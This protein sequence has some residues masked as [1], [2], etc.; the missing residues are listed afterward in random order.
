MTGQILWPP[1]PSATQPPWDGRAAMHS[2]RPQI[3]AQCCRSQESPSEVELASSQ[4]YGHFAEIPKRTGALTGLHFRCKI[5]KHVSSRGSHS[6]RPDPGGRPD[7]IPAVALGSSRAAVVQTDDSAD[8]RPFRA[9]APITDS[10]A[11]RRGRLRDLLD[12]ACPDHGRH[13]RTA[14]HRAGAAGGIYTG[15][16]FPPIQCRLGCPGT[17]PRP[18]GSLSALHV[19][20]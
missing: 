7:T 11:A 4:E 19:H 18:A 16:C 1:P 8:G 14:G 2:G 17:M 9:G 15:T 6:H 3:A 20:F 12:T 5:V 10:G 13:S